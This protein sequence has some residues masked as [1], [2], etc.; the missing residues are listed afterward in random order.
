[1]RSSTVTATSGKPT[2]GTS[3][4]YMPDIPGCSIGTYLRRGLELRS[5]WFDL[6]ISLGKD[7]RDSV[8]VLLHG[9]RGES[10]RR[11]GNPRVSGPVGAPEG[12][13]VIVRRPQGPFGSVH[14][15]RRPVH[16]SRT[17]RGVTS[18]GVE[19]Q[20]GCTSPL[21][22]PRNTEPDRYTGSDISS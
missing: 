9:P 22:S 8:G 16:P 2:V 3:T 17:D 6:T 4:H 19:D 13:G 21:R 1:M 15:S 10:R 12:L 18:T 20:T 5:F 7:P 11:K 14:G